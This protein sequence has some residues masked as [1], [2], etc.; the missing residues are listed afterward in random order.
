MNNSI[1]KFKCEKC[2][3]IKNYVIWKSIG[4]DNLFMCEFC[5][6]KFDVNLDIEI[7]KRLKK[8]NI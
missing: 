3:S 2:G 4:K 5:W 8:F 7:L 6:K 1:K